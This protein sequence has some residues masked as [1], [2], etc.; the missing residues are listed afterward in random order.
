MSNIVDVVDAE[1]RAEDELNAADKA[2]KEEGR[3]IGR[4]VRERIADGY[5]YYCVIEQIVGGAVRVEH[6]HIYDGYRVPM[7]ESMG[8][9]I[10][11]K[12]VKENI[13]MR[14]RWQAMFDSN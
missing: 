9:V 1:M 14:D 10:P 6:V 2:A 11:L 4:Y 7:I 5:A 13:E 8:C 12:Y 3:V